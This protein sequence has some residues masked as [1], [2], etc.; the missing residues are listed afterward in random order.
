MCAKGI[1][2]GDGDPGLA[3]Q[4]AKAFLRQSRHITD[5]L[6]SDISRPP[7]EIARRVGDLIASATALSLSTELSIK[8]LLLFVGITPPATHN[9]FKLFNDLPIP[10]RTAIEKEYDSRGATP[11]NRLSSLKIALWATPSARA[12]LPE[13]EP[14]P[15]RDISAVLKRSEDAFCTWRYLYERG[16][17]GTADVYEYEFLRLGWVCEIIQALLS[18]GLKEGFLTVPNP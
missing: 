11:R 6:S 1:N 18:R 9:L 17:G 5:G 13:S 7:N 10:I 8:A 3:L 15:K 4:A 14:E 2:R 16:D 12:A